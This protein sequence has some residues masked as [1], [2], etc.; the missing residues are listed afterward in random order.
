MDLSDEDMAVLG[1]I[2]KKYGV[3]RYIYPDFGVDL[4]FP[5]KSTQ[6]SA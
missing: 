5:D 3:K 1:E 4:G 6:G 2:P